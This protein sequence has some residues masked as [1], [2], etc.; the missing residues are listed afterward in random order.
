MHESREVWIRRV[1]RQ[2]KSGQSVREFATRNG[3]KPSTLSYWKWRLRQ[4]E[5][6]T[7]ATARDSRSKRTSSAPQPLPPLSFIEVRATPTAERFELE[8]RDGRRLRIPAGFEAT[9]L[10]RLLGVL[11]VRP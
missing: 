1:E 6:A 2:R 11:E 5:K 8:F 10:Q 7:P 4:D 3:F 9:A